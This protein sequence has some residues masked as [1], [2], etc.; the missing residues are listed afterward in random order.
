MASR[1]GGSS[2]GSV[3]D[4]TGRA[5][6]VSGKQ[7]WSRRKLA[8]LIAPLVAITVGGATLW[9]IPHIEANVERETRADLEAAGIDT[10]D[11]EIDARYRFVD[12][13]G[14]RDQAE[15]DRIASIVD[16]DGN[17]DVNVFVGDGAS[18]TGSTDGGIPAA[19]TTTSSPP[20]TTTAPATTAAPTITAPPTTAAPVETGLVEV[21]ALLTGDGVVLSGD[22]LTE[23]QRMALV[24]AASSNFGAANVEDQLNVTGLES[25]SGD[26]DER[27]ASVAAFLANAPSGV[28][29]TASLTDGAPSF[30]GDATSVDD[31]KTMEEVMEAVGGAATVALTERDLGTQ[32]ADLAD[33][34]M[35][36]RFA[37]DQSTLN[38]DAKAA[39]DALAELI[40]SSDAGVLE[41]SG[42]TCSMGSLEHNQTLSERRAQSVVDYLIGQGVDAERLTTRGAGE[43]EPIA[44]NDT[45][46]GRTQNRRVAIDLIDT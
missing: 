28:T 38:G 44:S 43:L 42:H 2:G 11:L 6:A 45:W 3:I 23:E 34:L 9:A 17:T 35:L 27:V 19:P 18:A 4:T 26:A 21:Q 30:M 16:F 29:G 10:T 39:L 15:A 31:A 12:V 13:R 46:F 20:A 25:E 32:L 41:I 8:A 36:L 7:P 14:A 1:V 5:T 33:Q 40:N 24:D 22:V 37:P